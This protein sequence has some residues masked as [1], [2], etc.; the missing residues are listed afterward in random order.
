MARVDENDQDRLNKK[1]QTTDII[2][3]QIARSRSS[4]MYTNFDYCVIWCKEISMCPHS[5]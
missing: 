1:N 3:K 5:N 4:Q 2:I